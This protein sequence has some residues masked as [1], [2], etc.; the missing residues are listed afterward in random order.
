M[1]LKF[2]TRK[3]KTQTLGDDEGD[4]NEITE[5]PAEDIRSETSKTKENIVSFIISSYGWLC[6][7]I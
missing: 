1:S 5:K 7:K 2:V 3:L 4:P 6:Y